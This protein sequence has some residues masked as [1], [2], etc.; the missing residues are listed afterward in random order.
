MSTPSPIKSP[1][2][3]RVAPWSP[4]H[5]VSGTN[6]QGIQSRIAHAQSHDQQARVRANRYLHSHIIPRIQREQ[7]TA[8]KGITET[9]RSRAG[10][11]VVPPTTSQGGTILARAYQSRNDELGALVK[12]CLEECQNIRETRNKQ[13]AAEAA[14]KAQVEETRAQVAQDARRNEARIIEARQE[15]ELAA[16]RE[17]AAAAVRKTNAAKLEAERKAGLPNLPAVIMPDSSQADFAKYQRIIQEMKSDVVPAVRANPALKKAAFDARRA[18][19]LRVGQLVNTRA[20]IIDKATA[21]DAA[22][23]TT[24]NYGE[25]LY[26]WA[27]NNTAKAVAGQAEVEVSVRSAT[28]YPIAHVCVLLCQNHPIFADILLARLAKRCPYIVPRFV[29]PQPGQSRPEY[30]KSLRYKK[31]N[32]QT[33]EADEQYYN[34]MSGLVA[35]YAALTQTIPL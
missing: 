25:A 16:T 14:R 1:L 2:S 17:A 4:N 12:N 11:M 23:K 15:A 20:S 13:R 8:H 7:D 22:I 34:R 19:M 33:P 3:T 24:Q 32:T 9:T 30:L 26:R 6:V 31:T 10:E 27:L 35:L 28:A 5:R 29:L 18:I 21:I